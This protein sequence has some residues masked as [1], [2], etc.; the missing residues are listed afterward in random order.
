M[1]EAR[2]PELPVALR[3]E[4]S[5]GPQPGTEAVELETRVEVRGLLDRVPASTPLDLALRLFV[6]LPS[7]TRLSRDARVAL[8]S[9]PLDGVVLHRLGLTVPVGSRDFRVEVRE[10][11]TGARGGSKPLEATS[12]PRPEG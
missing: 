5:A 1:E 2:P 9:I 7:G 10:S 12:E 3:V 8:D 4:R 6:T 11:T